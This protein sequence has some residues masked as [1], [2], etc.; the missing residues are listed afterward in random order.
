LKTQHG[1][2]H[3]NEITGYDEDAMSD[4]LKLTDKSQLQIE[5][6]IQVSAMLNDHRQHVL[7]ENLFE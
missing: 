2:L 4:Y 6:N 3:G 5:E 1:G 7:L